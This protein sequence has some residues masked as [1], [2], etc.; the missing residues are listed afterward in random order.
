MAWRKLR[1]EKF[2][3]KSRQCRA[4]RTP[5]AVPPA[6]RRPRR[7]GGPRRPPH[8]A[9]ALRPPGPAGS[10]I[11]SS[12][13]ARLPRREL[14]AAPVREGTAPVRC[15]GRQCHGQDGQPRR[16]GAGHLRPDTCGHMAFLLHSVNDTLLIVML[17]WCRS[18]GV[19]GSLIRGVMTYPAF[20]LTDG[21]GRRADRAG[22]GAGAHRGPRH[23][24]PPAGRAN[25]RPLHPVAPSWQPRTT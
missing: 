19:T 7:R 12:S 24:D 1:S 20:T 22:G 9:G 23:H 2:K 14:H 8:A 16:Y 5:P 21:D 6:P 4:S 18:G 11:W 15:R 25:G 3:T 10:A 17:A 13:T